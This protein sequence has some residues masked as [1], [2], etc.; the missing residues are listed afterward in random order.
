MACRLE[1]KLREE[2]PRSKRA[3]TVWQAMRSPT[4]VWMMTSVA[5][6]LG[7]G[8]SVCAYRCE[9]LILLWFASVRPEFQQ[10]FTAVNSPHL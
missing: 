8:S 10:P 7:P 5:E 4:I 1:Q 6:L 9:E 3:I 2:T